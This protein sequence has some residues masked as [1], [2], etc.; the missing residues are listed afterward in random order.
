MLRI[1]TLMSTETIKTSTTHNEVTIDFSLVSYSKILVPHD[2]S[3][4]SDR[5]LS[6]AAYIARMTGSRIELLHVLEHAKDIPPS[7]L[8]TLIGPDKPLEDAKEELQNIVEA[9]VR[10][11]MEE[12]VKICKDQGKIDQITYQ[13]EVGKPVDEIVRIAEKNNFDLIVMDS[14]RISSTIILLGST[15]K[16]VLDSIRKPVLIIHG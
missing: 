12:K 13:I 10:K 2:T 15:T 5:V 14:S 9:G 7:A 16:G 8:L 4:M 11:I 1:K 3:Q 6:H